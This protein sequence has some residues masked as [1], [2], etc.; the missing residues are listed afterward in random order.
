[1][2]D[3]PCNYVKIFEKNL[4]RQF[5]IFW[6]IVLF[7]FLLSGKFCRSKNR[8]HLINCTIIKWIIW[9]FWQWTKNL[10][11]KPIEIDIEWKIIV[12]KKCC[13]ANIRVHFSLTTVEKCLKF[14]TFYYHYSNVINLNFLAYF[15]RIW[16]KI[17]N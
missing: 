7:A 4:R 5:Q 6:V 15:N 11:F 14:I 12:L 10:R 16:L 1:M 8:I 13:K 3:F 9:Y 2:Y 17:C